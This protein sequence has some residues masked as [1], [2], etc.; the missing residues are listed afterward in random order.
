VSNISL[1]DGGVVWKL[2]ATHGL[3]IDFIMDYMWD[4]YKIIP[5]FLEILK[6]AKKD[7]TNIQ[8]LFKE[9]DGYAK[10][11]YGDEVYKKYVANQ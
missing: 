5:T 11:I 3:P 8:R 4:V 6:S 9:L 7:G 1:I 2:H 10:I